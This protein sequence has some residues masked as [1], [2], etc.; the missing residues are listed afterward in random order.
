MVNNA[1]MIITLWGSDAACSVSSPQLPGIVA[2]FDDQPNALELHKLAVAAGLDPDGIFDVHLENAFEV[3]GVTYLVRTRHDHSSDRRTAIAKQLARAISADANLRKYAEADNFDDV[4]FVT[5]LPM[6]RV[7]DIIASVAAGQPLTVGMVDDEGSISLVGLS[8]NDNDGT[9]RRNLSDFGLDSES[10][11]GDLFG[12]IE[13]TED[14]LLA[15][16][17]KVSEHLLLLA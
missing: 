17:T 16:R 7:K 6:D 8:H 5:A 3:D 11:I 2:A 9:R 14:D 10:T 15:D 12:R 4:L 13:D 1:Q